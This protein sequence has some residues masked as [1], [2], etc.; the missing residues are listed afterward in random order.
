MGIEDKYLNE[1][2]KQ[3]IDNLCYGDDDL[4]MAINDYLYNL[5]DKLSDLSKQMNEDMEYLVRQIKQKGNEKKN[6]M[7][8]DQ[9]KYALKVYINDYY[10]IYTKP[11]IDWIGQFIDH[12]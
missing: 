2:K 3:D 12:K 5:Q 4:R 1:S 6:K 7:T 11:S 8:D 9:I 10:P